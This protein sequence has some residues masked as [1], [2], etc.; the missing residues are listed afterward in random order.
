MTAEPDQR[1]AAHVEF[2]TFRS[3]G[4][5]WGQM[6]ALMGLTGFAISQPLLAVA[7]EDTTLFTFAG[8]SGWGLVAFALIVALVPPLVL[9]CVVLLA[10]RADDRLGDIVFVV[11]SALLAGATAIQWAKTIASLEQA[12]LL[13]AVGLM[14]TAGFA[15]ALLLAR[16][17]ALWTRFTAVLPPIAVILLL[18]AS[19]ASDLLRSRSAAPDR[20]DAADVG[21]EPLPSVVF[22]MLD[23]LPLRS[24]LAEDGTIDEIRFPNFAE[25]ADESTW[26]RDY[27]VQAAGT[28]QSVPSILTSQEPM[29]KLPLWT[30]HP[31]S[32]FSLLAPTHDLVAAEPVTQIC[33]FSN[34]EIEGA[35]HDQR[36][37][38]RSV[39][40]QMRDV[41]FDRVSLGPL[42]EVDLDQF[43]A[44]AVP[45]DPDVDERSGADGG[46]A[47]RNAEAPG[48]V[49]DFIRA[50]EG[51]EIPSLAYLHLMLPHQPWMRYPDGRVFQ[52]WTQLELAM[53]GIEQDEWTRTLLKQA[54]LFQAE[55]TDRLLGELLDEL[56][57]Q[58][59]Y[60]DALVVVT[61]DHGVAFRGEQNLRAASAETMSSIAYVPL[62]VKSPGQDKGRIDDSNLMGIDLLPTIAAEVGVDI[63]WEVEGFPVGSPEIVA[64]GTQKEFYDFGA[65]FGRELLDVIEFDTEEHRPTGQGSLIGAIGTDEHSLAALARTVD[66]DVD[67]DE[68]LGAKL[69]DLDLSPAVERAT[70]RG[71]GALRR[72][73][74]EGAP[75]RVN[76]LVPEALPGDAVLLAVDGE[77]QSFSPVHE[78]G[79][80]LLFIPPE[81][82]ARPEA[83]VQLLRVADGEAALLEVRGT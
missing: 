10:G 51:S 37:G 56:R 70:T 11:I 24:I 17:V 35:E 52:G 78:G 29:G 82:R 76:G 14:A 53:D 32:L 40:A 3:R 67:V 63:P 5:S 79:G 33:G 30:R 50:M 27:T 61:A 64:R 7:G 38:I 59:L 39:L 46:P 4:F 21:G 9:W 18:V 65:D 45:L 80:F 44:A 2:P 26:Y 15:G 48:V 19:P 55:Y 57:A 73:D 49:V 69:E 74:H 62:M 66:V 54:H 22:V 36:G 28:I 13:A 41:W 58:D 34:C 16:P 23:E 6:W 1:P 71:I 42:P 12:W 31:D 60:D 72:E 20:S 25:F 8:V 83:E 68:W 43:A 81:V 77:V 47:D 75:G